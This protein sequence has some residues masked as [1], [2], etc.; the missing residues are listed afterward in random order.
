MRSRSLRTA[1]VGW[2]SIHLL[3]DFFYGSISISGNHRLGSIDTTSI[4][5][6]FWNKV[7]RLFE[8]AIIVASYLLRSFVRNFA[9]IYVFIS[10]LWLFSLS[11]SHGVD[12]W[13]RWSDSNSRACRRNASFHTRIKNQTLCQVFKNELRVMLLVS[14][15]FVLLEIMSTSIAFLRV[16]GFIY[17]YSGYSW[18]YLQA[19]L[20]NIFS[21][22][23]HPGDKVFVYLKWVLLSLCISSILSWIV[24]CDVFPWRW[25]GGWLQ[26]HCEYIKFSNLK[27]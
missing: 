18:D 4:F 19:S 15:F 14:S 9:W 17:T 10:Q 11:L 12:G 2:G 26:H 1:Y 25:Q 27:W 21:T 5:L 8:K 3:L 7:S 23:L 20:L 13:N 24:T 16:I 6:Y 22:W